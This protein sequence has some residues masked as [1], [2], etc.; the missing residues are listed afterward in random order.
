MELAG[1]G[2]AG[3]APGHWPSWLAQGHSGEGGIVEH[4]LTEQRLWPRRT[5]AGAF[6]F[7]GAMLLSIE[8]G[9]GKH[10]LI[11]EHS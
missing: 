9:T 10:L 4:E 3:A 1:R 2:G 11:W 8:M 7:P 5:W 6:S